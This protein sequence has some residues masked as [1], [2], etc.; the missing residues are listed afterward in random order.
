MPME[1]PEQFEENH[2]FD[3][4]NEAKQQ[5]VIE[6][7]MKMTVQLGTGSNTIFRDLRQSQVGNADNDQ[8]SHMSIFKN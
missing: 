7:R 8:M 6:G 1:R 4:A 2:V 5:I 3:E